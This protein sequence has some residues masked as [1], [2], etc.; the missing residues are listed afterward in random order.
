MRPVQRELLEALAGPTKAKEQALEGNSE[1]LARARA[2][3]DRV[4]AARAGD[5]NNAAYRLAAKLVC[6]FDLPPGEALAVLREWAA[7][8]SPPLEEAELAA[9]IEHAARYAD[10]ERGSKLTAAS[11]ARPEPTRPEQAARAPWVPM[12]EVLAD[13]AERYRS[14]R[15][16]EGYV[17]TGLRLLDQATGGLGP[18]QLVLLGGRPGE[19][20]SALALDIARHVS[21]EHGPVLLLSLEMSRLEVAGR[22]VQ[23]HTQLGADHLDAGRVESVISA[24]PRLCIADEGSSLDEV[25]SLADSFRRAH[26]DAALIIIDYLGLISPRN[27]PQSPYERVSA[28]VRALK[29]LAQSLHLPVIALVQLR[30]PPKG[31]QDEPPDLTDMRDSGELEQAANKVLLLHYRGAATQGPRTVRLLL[32]KNREGGKAS[33]DLHFQPATVSMHTIEPRPEPRSG[34]DPPYEE[35]LL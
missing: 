35:L 4:D 19:G 34:L 18:G 33:I 13:L 28:V 16:R 23:Q 17:T 25:L 20:K 12:P 31:K 3:A 8:C 2:Y 7:R 5:R 1:G 30:R 26:P 21:R 29:T 11:P 14:G 27:G 22:V 6:D 32:A 10:G 9:T 15:E 24:Y